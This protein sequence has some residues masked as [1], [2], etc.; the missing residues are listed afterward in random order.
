MDTSIY[1]DADVRG[2]GIGTVLYRDLL[3]RLRALGYVSA[4]AGI[5]MPN[6]AS[7]ALHERVGFVPTGSFPVAGFKLGRWIDVSLWRCGLA[8]LP[9]QPTPPA[10]C[11]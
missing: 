9:E 5:A 8:D 3:A 11:M 2:R 6:P 10:P 1:L 7:V 4:F